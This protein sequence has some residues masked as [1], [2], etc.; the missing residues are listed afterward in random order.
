MIL[1]YVIIEIDTHLYVFSTLHLSHWD[2]NHRP[3]MRDEISPAGAH[4]NLICKSGRDDQWL[5]RKAKWEKALNL[6]LSKQSVS[7]IP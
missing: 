2:V 6:R 7:S 1:L 4:G 5:L 3:S